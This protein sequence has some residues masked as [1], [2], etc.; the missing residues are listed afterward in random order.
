V[1]V[2]S[3]P[4][5]TWIKFWPRPEDNFGATFPHH[6][7]TCDVIGNSQMIIQ[8][9]HFPNMTEDCDV[10]TIYGQHGLDLGKANSKGAKWAAFDPNLTTYQ[11]PTEIAKTIGGGPTGGATVLAPTAGWK[12]RDLQTQFGRQYTPTPRTPTRFI[13]TATGNGT[14]G[15]EN[16]NR[17]AIIGGAVGGA[18]GGLLLVAAIGFC[19]FFYR[20]RRATR[21]QNPAPRPPSELPSNPPMDSVKSATV[22]SFHGH[23]PSVTQYTHT[24]H[25]SPPP[26][27]DHAWSHYSHP[28]SEYPAQTLY[29]QPQPQLSPHHRSPSDQ[30]YRG[31]PPQTSPAMGGY[32]KNS[33]HS[34]TSAR[35]EM[36]IVRS[37]PSFSHA[38]MDTSIQPLNTHNID[39]YFAQNPPQE[40]MSPRKN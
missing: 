1:Y 12:Q 33:P 22:S 16:S 4:S 9:G 21:E 2:L 37:P 35:H 27:S 7:L 11:V 18:I 32:E 6:S 29:A 36:P 40:G 15:P 13:P 39:P 34:P 26:P 30:S 25:G 17:G 28:P 20:R 10:P 38:E 31:Y 5:F 14:A 8:G 24:P 3:L 23:S 19:I